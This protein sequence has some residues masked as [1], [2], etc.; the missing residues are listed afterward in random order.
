MSRRDRP[1]LAYYRAAADV[2]TAREID[3]T[4]VMREVGDIGFTSF[5]LKL[6]VKFIKEKPKPTINSTNNSMQTSE[7]TEIKWI[8]EADVSNCSI[9]LQAFALGTLES[10]REN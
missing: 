7:L 1:Q 4:D 9:S 10:N 6:F 8:P 5:Q 3:E 2:A